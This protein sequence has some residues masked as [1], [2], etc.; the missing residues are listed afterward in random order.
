MLTSYISSASGSEDSQFIFKELL[1]GGAK[2]GKLLKSAKI[3]CFLESSGQ[4]VSG[5]SGHWSLALVG[6]INLLHLHV[7]KLNRRWTSEDFYGNF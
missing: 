5:S 4:T 3:I 1:F 2:V 6:L 7:V